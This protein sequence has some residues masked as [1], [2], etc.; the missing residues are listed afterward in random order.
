MCHWRALGRLGALLLPPLHR[1]PRPRAVAHLLCTSWHCGAVVGSAWREGGTRR[2]SW[3]NN[4]FSRVN[5]GADGLISGVPFPSCRRRVRVADLTGLSALICF[6]KDW[7]SSCLRPLLDL[8]L[9]S[10]NGLYPMLR[11]GRGPQ[12]APRASPPLTAFRA[13]PSDLPR[14]SPAA[15]GGES[16]Q[17]G[18]RYI[19][20]SAVPGGRPHH[21]PLVSPGP[22]APPGVR[23]GGS[24]GMR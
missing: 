2:S 7:S 14:S 8:Q 3:W 9:A 12:P 18:L 5:T 24:M 13:E 23:G 20:H 10:S 19:H 21:R 1:D 15:L 22:G 6:K 16:L 17:S 11:E 4:S